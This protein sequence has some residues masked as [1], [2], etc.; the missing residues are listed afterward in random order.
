VAVARDLLAAGRIQFKNCVLNISE[1][2]DK[3]EVDSDVQASMEPDVS[4]TVQVC[5]FNC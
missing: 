3:T 5:H 2:C 4:D 1:P